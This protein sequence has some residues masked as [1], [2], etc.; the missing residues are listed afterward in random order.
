MS[1]ASLTMSLILFSKSSSVSVTPSVQPWQQSFSCPGFSTSPT[2][3]LSSHPGICSLGLP[4]PLVSTVTQSPVLSF[5]SELSFC[6]PSF[7]QPEKSS[8]NIFCR[9]DLMVVNSQHLFILKYF[10]L[11]SFGRAAFLDRR[12]TGDSLLPSS[13]LSMLPCLLPCTALVS[14]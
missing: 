5:L 10:T 8:F 12:F 3:P 13:I 11:L 4:L 7:L 2:Q 1:A 6:T 9:T 14:T